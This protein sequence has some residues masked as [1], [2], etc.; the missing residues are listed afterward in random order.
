[1]TTPLAKRELFGT[2]F[3]KKLPVAWYD[4]HLEKFEEMYPSRD[5]AYVLH[6][7]HI[8]EVILLNISKEFI[9]RRKE[10]YLLSR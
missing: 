8:L 9:M 2:V 10:N 3:L 1:M 4:C 5:R 7:F 6:M